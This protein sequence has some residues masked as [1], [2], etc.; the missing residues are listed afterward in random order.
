MVPFFVPAVWFWNTQLWLPPRAPKILKDMCFLSIW[1][2]Q[3][4]YSLWIPTV[5]YPFWL[6]HKHLILWVWANLF[7]RL[8]LSWLSNEGVDENTFRGLFFW[9][10]KLKVST[11]AFQPGVVK[12]GLLAT[13]NPQTY[14]VW[15]TV[16][17]EFCQH[18]LNQQI[19]AKN[20]E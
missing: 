6:S 17:I 11:Q 18:F 19:S 12:R 5:L 16:S 4:P 9:H 1:Q 20:S 15:P 8:P 3:V 13:L 7:S 2:M 10:L 14:F